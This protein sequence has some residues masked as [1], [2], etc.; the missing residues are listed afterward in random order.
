MQFTCNAAQLNR[1]LT[2]ANL[3]TTRHAS[4]P[5]LQHVH[6]DAEGRHIKMRA[7]NLS[8]GAEFTIPAEVISPGACLIDVSLVL[9]VVGALPATT[10]IS[11]TLEGNLLVVKTDRSES[12]MKTLSLEDFP[13][14]PRIENPQELQIQAGTLV[15]M[16]NDVVYAASQSD[17]KPEI[18]SVFMHVNEPSQELIA[19]CTDSFRLSERREKI[20]DP[21]VM[22][23]SMIPVKNIAIA[24]RILNDYEKES[25]QVDLGETQVNFRSVSGDL[26]MTSRLVDGN[27]PEYDKIIPK[28]FKSHVTLLKSDLVQSLKALNV[29][30]DKFYQIDMTIDSEKQHIVVVSQHPERGQHTAEVAARVE[31]DALSIRL[32][33]RYLQDCLGSV[34][35]SSIV[36]SFTDSTKPMILQGLDQNGFLYLV[37]P[38]YR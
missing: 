9:G 3:M 37:M 11:V 7:T 8:I 38:M 25:I 16:W 1:A 4:L 33:A 15:G 17:I 30:A 34:K 22:N 24:S 5:V 32:N 31:G 29:F 14:L 10:K 21:I 18:S 35:S 36:L 20:T 28:E 13:T 12:T 2:H 26:Y 6:L 27:Y 23:G 19:V